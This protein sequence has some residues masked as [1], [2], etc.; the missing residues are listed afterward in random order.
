MLHA[1]DLSAQS[2]ASPAQRPAATAESGPAPF[3]CCL[4]GLLIIGTGRI[5]AAA[6]TPTVALNGTVLPGPWVSFTY[7]DR[8]ILAGRHAAAAATLPTAIESLRIVGDNARQ[9]LWTN[10]RPVS[11]GIGPEALEFRL[12]EL[13]APERA[14]VLALLLKLPSE[15]RLLSESLITG[16]AGLIRKYT[17]TVESWSYPLATKI[18]Y[19]RF[20][21]PSK[22]PTTAPIWVPVRVHLVFNAQ[23][24]PLACANALVTGGDTVHLV[25]P[26]LGENDGGL[27]TVAMPNGM[28]TMQLAPQPANRATSAIEEIAGRI[29]GDSIPVKLHLLARCAEIHRAARNAETLNAGN[30]IWAHTTFPYR[31]YVR[32]EMEFGI[33][34]EN[35]LPVPGKGLLII[36]WL[37][38]P[39]NLL[40]ALYVQDGLGRRGR[41]ESTMYR[42][43][44]PDVR[45]AFKATPSE[46]PGFVVFQPFEFAE[47]L[48][49]T[50]QVHAILKGGIAIDLAT[51]LKASR[52]FFAKP[53]TLLNLFPAQ[54]FD[55][56]VIDK[57]APAIAYLQ[58]KAIKRSGIARKVQYGEPVK[59]PMLSIVVPLYRR[60]DH[61]RHQ[62]VHFANDPEFSQIELIY[63]LDAPELETELD[64]MIASM[65]R[66][67]QRSITLAIMQENSGFAGATNAGCGVA[68]G[69]HLLL[70]NS[71]VIPD[72]PGWCSKLWNVLE[73]D[74]KVGAVGARLL[75]EDGSLQH[76]GMAYELDVAGNWKV[77]HPGKGFRVG[78]P[79]EPKSGP[80]PAVTAACMMMRTAQYHQ[81]GGLNQDY[82]IGDFEDSDLCMKIASLPLTLWYCSDATLFHLERQSMG[83]DGRYT[84][85]TWRYNQHLHQQRWGRLIQQVQAKFKS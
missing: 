26:Q 66:I 61:A 63:V 54:K 56:T 3:A 65:S 79:G 46:P 24:H 69:K 25:I 72:Q 74:E 57:L 47:D 13:S 59:D 53:E 76:A 44:R 32:P 78:H 81:L 7:G 51:D 83:T 82:V 20:T 60:I 29:A 21:L 19:C 28:F 50:Y 49:P 48:W 35:M 41:V 23:S 55:R 85:T 6:R 18:R 71:D 33:S 16:V 27:L 31:A 22:S 8:L 77:V 52:R 64:T 39:N 70:L 12:A 67:Y 30:L 73:K 4:D 17:A 14:V 11:L 2:A 15:L 10:E 80:V 43:D 34:I 40:D 5:S 9:I 75:Y 62:I 1:L 38:D 58:S 68:R 36:G 37:W 45:D 42:Y 84:T